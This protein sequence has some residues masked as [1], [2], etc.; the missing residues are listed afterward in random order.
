MEVKSYIT[1]INIRMIAK[2]QGCYP[3]VKLTLAR[4]KL[5]RML[6]GHHRIGRSDNSASIDLVTS[7]VPADTQRLVIDTLGILVSEHQLLA[8]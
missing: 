8:K 1:Y 7:Q 2:A 3:P 6:S 4:N 5:R